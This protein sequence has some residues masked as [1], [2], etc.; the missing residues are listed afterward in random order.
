MEDEPQVPAWNIEPPRNPDAIKLLSDTLVENDYDIKPVLRVLFNSDFFKDA[1][2]KKV[3]NPT[4]VVVSTLEAYR[5]P[6]RP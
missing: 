1:M 2:Y 6:P 5:R 3:K 4:E